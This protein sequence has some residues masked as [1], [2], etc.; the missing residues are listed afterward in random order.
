[1]VGYSTRMNGDEEELRELKGIKK[2]LSIIRDRTANPRRTFLNGIVY[3]A[4]A[5][6]GGILAVMLL[7]WVLNVLGIIPGFSDL[8]DY[9]RSL[10][11]QL[12]SRR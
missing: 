11:A 12:P 5:L 6:V 10:I 4:G 2:E 7:G 8:A 1:M 3:G 9:V